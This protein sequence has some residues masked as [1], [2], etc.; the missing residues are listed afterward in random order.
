MEVIFTHKF[1]SLSVLN[2][3]RVIVMLYV[4][5]FA[6]FL[7]SVNSISVELRQHQ[8]ND[9]VKNIIVMMMVDVAVLI[10]LRLFAVL[11]RLGL[12][13]Y[14]G[15]WFQIVLCVI[16]TVCII[17]NNK[18]CDKL[19]ATTK[20]LAIN[21]VKEQFLDAAFKL[22]MTD[23]D[24]LMDFFQSDVIG[25][26]TQDTFNTCVNGIYTLRQVVNKLHDE[27]VSLIDWIKIISLLGAFIF[28][29]ASLDKNNV[30]SMFLMMIRFMIFSQQLAKKSFCDN[31][32]DIL[33]GF[34]KKLGS[35]SRVIQVVRIACV[36][37]KCV[38]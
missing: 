35:I 5:Q 34:K 23:L 27:I 4:V 21:F 7:Q 26:L 32:I 13:L 15:K 28:T 29:F 16:Q 24:V 1:Y 14:F 3:K 12:Y 11:I 31:C 33:S 37:K 22:E 30:M 10:D 19:I 20:Q 8:I 2:I 38:S 9:S 18:L 6:M 25:K 17:W 36:V